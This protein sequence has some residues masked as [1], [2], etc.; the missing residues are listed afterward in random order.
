MT[1]PPPHRP[2]QARSQ[3]TR[4]RFILAMVQLLEAQEYADIT[5]EAIAMAA[6]STVPSFYKHFPGKRELLAAML[7][8]L[9][10]AAEAAQEMPPLPELPLAGRV[11][12]LVATVAE[13]TMR[14]RR[15]VR[16]CVAARYRADLVLT[17]AQSDRL[18][19]RTQ[20]LIDWLLECRSE[21]DRPDSRNSIRAGMF[22]ALQGLQSALLFE[23]LPPELPE[24]TLIAEA[25]RML[26]RFLAA[27]VAKASN[28]DLSDRSEGSPTSMISS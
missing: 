1:Q 12:W 23:E 28:F 5:V 15:L 25:E 21:L 17:P 8:T 27:P 3:D 6:H 16:A 19:A 22:I 14:R 10:S 4:R 24:A 9:Q 18:R 13:T 2:K 26:L 20:R 7:D 11:A